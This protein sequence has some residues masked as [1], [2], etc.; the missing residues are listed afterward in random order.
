MTTEA[1]AFLV[2]PTYYPTATAAIFDMDGLLVDSEPFWRRVEIEVFSAIGVDIEPLLG[3]GLTMGMRVDEVVAFFRSRVAW[4]E[5]SDDVIVERIV[6]GIVEAI[7]DEAELLPGAI[8]AV[9]HVAAHDMSVALASG[10]V[11]PVI[12]AVLDR[13]ALRERFRVVSSAVDDVLGKPH[14]AIFL[15]TA[16]ALGVDPL[17]CVVLEDSINGCIAAKAAR[18]RAIAVPD[19][20]FAAESRYAI[21]DLRLASLLEIGGPR[22]A[23][24][25]GWAPPGSLA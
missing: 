20:R 22:V 9:E 18:M 25:L 10:S 13:F 3:S 11:P 17:A 4:D 12:D 7:W 14:P 8:E 24:V 21:A 2:T 1:P 15:R 19:E 6:A 16:A 23:E 5:P